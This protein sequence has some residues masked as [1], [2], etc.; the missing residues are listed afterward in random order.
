MHF[1][2]CERPGRVYVGRLPIAESVLNEN[3]GRNNSRNLTKELVEGL[4]EELQFWTEWCRVREP[5]P[6]QS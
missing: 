5:E 4:I 1:L 6:D 2:N 3:S